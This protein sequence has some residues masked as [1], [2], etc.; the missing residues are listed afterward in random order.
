MTLRTGVVRDERYL[1]HKTGHIHPDHPNR[2]R[3]IYRMLE[4]FSEC[5]IHI[6]PEPVPLEYLELV[7]TPVYIE[8]VL[9]TADQEFT[10]LAPDT[11][12]SPESYLAAWLA[13]GGCLKA[14]DALIAGDC[15]VC[16]ALVRPPGHH[17]LPDRAGGF[18]IFNNLG[19]TA[20]YAMEHHGLKRIMIIDWDIHHGNG[21]QELFYE[22]KTVLFFSSHDT[23]LYP[24]TGDFEEAG[25][26][27]GAGY[28]INMP[29][30]RELEDGEVLFLYREILT[31]VLESFRPELLLV[32]A[33]FDAHHKD[34]IGRS[35]WTENAYGWLTDLLV[36]GREAVNGPPML[37]ALEGGYHPRA[38]ANSVR[39]VIKVLASDQVRDH[40]PYK[41][42]PR[43][44]RI[45]EK[46]RRVHAKYGVWTG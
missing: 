21:I 22:E 31:P 20:R 46:V 27:H 10:S 23:L 41:K 25:R 38:T 43:A 16:F 11:P 29:V 17:A 44:L 6:Q 45:I 26:G 4:D 35:L 5:L 3:A 39:E 15:D 13:V 28:T 24:Y 14:L 1:E 34:P 40:V 2:L 42:T 19:T 7:H 12:A 8:K 30:G 33:G 37:F 18:C 36:D 9:K 32:A